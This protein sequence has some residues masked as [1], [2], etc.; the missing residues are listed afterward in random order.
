MLGGNQSRANTFAISNPLGAFSAPAGPTGTAGSAGAA[1]TAAT[2]AP[3]APAATAVRAAVNGTGKPERKKREKKI[4]DPNEPKRP[5]TAFFLFLQHARPIVT[6]DLGH[7][8]MPVE[9]SNEAT[10]RWQ[11]MEDSEKQVSRGGR[12]SVSERGR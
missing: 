11:R 10:A 6:K 12:P 1:A 9:V 8:A 7:K 4:K 3:A 5:L 2:A